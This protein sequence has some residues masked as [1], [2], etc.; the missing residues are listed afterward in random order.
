ML[1][2]LMMAA[3]REGG[4]RLRMGSAIGRWEV[5]LLLEEEEAGNND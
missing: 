5:V 2:P 1:G 3:T 4:G